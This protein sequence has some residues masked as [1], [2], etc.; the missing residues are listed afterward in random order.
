MRLREIFAMTICCG[1]LL[2]TASQ[3]L[4]ATPLSPEKLKIAGL[5]VAAWLP[6]DGTP[7]PWP[8]IIFSHGFRGCD[9][10]SS[11]LMRALAGAGYAIFAPNHRDAVC[12]KLSGWLGRPEL[13]FRNP[14]NWNDQTYAD[15]AQDI[16]NLLN[17]LQ[18]DPHYG[19]AP[20]D[21]NHVGLIGH[22]LGGYTV[23][24]IGGAWPRWKDP[25]VK[26]I[27]ALSPYTAPF[28]LHNT[29][30][31]I[32][33]PVMYQGGTRDTGISQ[34]LERPGGAYEQT[35]APKYLVQLAG[36]GHFA[37]I[38]MRANAK[39]NLIIEYG[40]AFLDQYLKSRPFPQSLEQP[41]AG[42]A[43]LRFQQ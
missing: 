11:F 28:V 1:I 6:P 25:R 27:L 10:Q 26:A 41:V 33:A 16:E 22:S 43:D 30:Q 35:P 14:E 12:G 37:W 13:P 34:L 3:A 2:L 32:D 42:I 17:A 8:V 20:F 31:N 24:E 29:L 15:R 39:H 38:D 7:A 21:W 40:R 18:H 19:A 36:A 5:E 4:A 23:L 9:T